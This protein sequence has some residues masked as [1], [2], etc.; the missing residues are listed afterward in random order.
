MTFLIPLTLKLFMYEEKFLMDGKDDAGPTQGDFRK[1]TESK[2][3]L[4]ERTARCFE[5][6]VLLRELL[7]R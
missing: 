2:T 3:I 6:K 7:F 4:Y 1:V 5:M